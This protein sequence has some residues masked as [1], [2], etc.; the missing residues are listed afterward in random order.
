MVNELR[1]EP[2]PKR[3]RARLGQTTVADTTRALLVWEPREIVPG[4]AVPDEDLSAELVKPAGTTGP[5]HNMPGESLT[6]R[7]GGTEKEGA[8]FRPAD[9]DF[10]RHVILSFEAFDW[11]EED[12]PIR[13]HP[14]DPFHRVDVRQ[15][16]RKVRVELD[17]ELL[18]ESSRARMVFETK[19]PPRFYLPREDLRAELIRP[20]SRHTIC[21]YKGDASYLS[22][23]VGTRQVND[24]AWSYEK[25]LPDAV[26]IAGF[27]AFFDE[28]VDMIVDGVLRPRPKTAWSK[29]EP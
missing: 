14:R 1:Y 10:A 24:L 20:S 13:G 4:Y 19:L 17:G 11:L 5:K 26:E 21:A 7:A 16:S 27:V 23:A 12:E 3:V 29:P 22:F 6:V 9:P 15:S 18:A 8:A 25:P 2:T 28:R